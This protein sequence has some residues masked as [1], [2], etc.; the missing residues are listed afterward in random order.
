MSEKSKWLVG[1]KHSNPADGFEANEDCPHCGN[2][3]TLTWNVDED[4]YKVFCPHCGEKM[5]LCGEC[6]QDFFGLGLDS[7]CNWSESAGCFREK[8]EHLVQ[9]E[10]KE[11]AVH[12]LEWTGSVISIGEMSSEMIYELN[13]DDF[14]DHWFTRRIA[15]FV[16]EDDNPGKTMREFKHQLACG[17]LKDHVRFFTPSSTG[18]FVFDVSEDYASVYSDMKYRVFQNAV[19]E[20]N[21]NIRQDEMLSLGFGEKI[22][23]LYT[24]YNDKYGTYINM[25]TEMDGSYDYPGDGFMTFDD[26]ARTIRPR[27]KYYVGQ[28][29]K[30]RSDYGRG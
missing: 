9:G 19:R 5:M 8:G 16:C 12:Q 15:T 21:Y 17:D 30:Y 10:A 18:A 23:D 25:I 1:P 3:N 14:D 7:V 20:F 28:S 24:K 27:V 29:I 22:M 11:S 6:A 2:S 4:G 26:F 13:T